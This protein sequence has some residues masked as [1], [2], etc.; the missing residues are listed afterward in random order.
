MRFSHFLRI[1]RPTF[2]ESIGDFRIYTQGS[3][4]PL[5]FPPIADHAFPAVHMEL[6]PGLGIYPSLGTADLGSLPLYGQISSALY[7][8]KPQ[9]PPPDVKTKILPSLRH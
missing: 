5:Y 8:Q 9:T 3:L 2:R 7:P 6:V 4:L 1:H